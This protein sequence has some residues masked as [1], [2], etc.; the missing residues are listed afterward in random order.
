[1]K[2]G[3]LFKWFSSKWL[4]A[5]HYPFPE[6]DWIIERYAGGAGYSLNHCSCDVLIW[7]DDPNLQL[8]W[9]WLIEVATEDLIRE[10]PIDLPAGTDIRE[11]GLTKGQ[12]LLLKHWQRTNN[13][14]DCWTT[15]PWGSLPGQWTASTRARVAEEVQAIKHWKFGEASSSLL[16]THFIDPP[17]LYNY[18]FSSKLPPFNYE[19]LVEHV[20]SIRADSQVIVCEAVCPKTGKVP[21]YLPFVPSHRA[22]TS[23]RKSTQSH[24]SQEL[25][26]VRPSNRIRL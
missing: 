24:H 1:M 17:Y 5:K 18:R 9:P 3:P 20:Q 26:Y 21:T 2:I 25:I 12:A 4:S 23:R 14:G 8:L 22:I 6:H 16:A 10:I 15:S 13:V 7:E 11:L 19:T